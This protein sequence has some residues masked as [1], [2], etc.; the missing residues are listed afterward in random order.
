LRFFLSRFG[1]STFSS[2]ACLYDTPF[3]SPSCSPKSGAVCF[4][5]SFYK[6][7]IPFYL[8]G[9]PQC[10]KFAMQKSKMDKSKTTDKQFKTVLV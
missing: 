5:N 10:P 1:A 7:F 9:I 3:L 2:E 4:P 8:H 6:N